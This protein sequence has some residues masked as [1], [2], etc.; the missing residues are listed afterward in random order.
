MSWPDPSPEAALEAPDGEGRAE[1]EPPEEVARRG[2]AQVLRQT[3]GV[4][5]DVDHHPAPG[6]GGSDHIGL[7]AL[8]QRGAVGRGHRGQ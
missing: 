8:D 4:E 5:R 1:H 6:R 3:G 2:R 7:Q